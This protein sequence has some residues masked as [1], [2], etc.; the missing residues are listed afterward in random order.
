MNYSK[1]LITPMIG[2]RFV[3]F[4]TAFFTKNC[5]ACRLNHYKFKERRTIYLECLAMLVACLRYSF[6]L[7]LF[8]SHLTLSYRTKY[9]LYKSCSR[10]NIKKRLKQLVLLPNL[11]Y[12]LISGQIKHTRSYFSSGIHY[13][14]NKQTCF[15]S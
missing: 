11:S 6:T 13:L 14:R 1:R 10:F 9:G 2:I 12:C 4:K 15:I 5:L 3:I 8:L 7:Q